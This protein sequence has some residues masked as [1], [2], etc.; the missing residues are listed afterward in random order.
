MKFQTHW[1]EVDCVIQILVKEISNIPLYM[2]E[3][4]ILFMNFKIVNA[5]NW[6]MELKKSTKIWY[7]YS[8]RFQS[9]AGTRRYKRGSVKKAGHWN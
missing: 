6:K 9:L 8:Q 4:R 1:N 7:I 3:K 5:K 2:D